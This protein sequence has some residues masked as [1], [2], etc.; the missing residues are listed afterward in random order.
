MEV[1][2]VTSSTS[3]VAELGAIAA[4]AE[5]IISAMNKMAAEFETDCASCDFQEVCDEADGLRGMRDRLN[6]KTRKAR[7]G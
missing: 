2:Y 5:K 3:D 7:Y 4:P 6:E 1:I